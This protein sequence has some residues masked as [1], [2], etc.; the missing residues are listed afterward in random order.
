MEL[1]TPKDELILPQGTVVFRQGDP[2]REMFLIAAGRIRLTIGSGG[3]EHELAVLGAGEFLGDLALLSDEPRTATA[4]AIEDSRLVV[5]SRDVFSMMVQ[6]DLEIVAHMLSIQGRRLRRANQPIQELSRRLDHVRVAAHCLSRVAGSRP[7]PLPAS[8]EVAQ[9]ASELGLNEQAVHRIA[10][11]LVR[12]GVGTLQ[13]RHWI[14]ADAAQVAEL[15]EAL[16]RYAN[17]KGE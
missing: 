5:I 13:S 3:H 12:C 1:S 16:C 17:G 9:L 14:I 8:I 6:D 11:D 15:I 7:Q 2:G 10:A 4:T